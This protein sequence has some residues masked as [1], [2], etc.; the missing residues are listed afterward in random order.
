MDSKNRQ[1][2]DVKVVFPLSILPNVLLNIRSP[3]GLHNYKK[4]ALKPYKDIK[5][6]GQFSYIFLYVIV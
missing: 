5:D 2:E 4:G 3:F 1:G 6:Y